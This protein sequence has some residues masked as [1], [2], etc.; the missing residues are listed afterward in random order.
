MSD[1]SHTRSRGFTWIELAMVIGVLAILA[2]MAIP[3]LEDA[4]IKKQVRAGLSLADLAKAGVQTA[5]SLT[6]AMPPNN[7]AAGLPAADKIVGTY[8]RE[9]KVEGGAVTLT[10]GNA[11]SALLRDK[12]VTLRPAVVPGEPRVPI[13]WVCHDS[14]VPKGMEIA[15]EDRTN[16]PP[17]HLPVECRAAK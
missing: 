15:G 6:G 2:A 7:D 3:G 14:L 13:A 4:A 1:K 5:F 9:V 10:Y 11:V 16:I 12:Q 8:V 17:N